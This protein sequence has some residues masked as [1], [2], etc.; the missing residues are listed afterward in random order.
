MGFNVASDEEIRSG[1][2]TD[3]YFVRTVRTL[4]SAGI[5]KRVVMEVTTSSLP[6][7]YKWAVLAGIDEVVHL[8]EGKPV[9]VDCIPEGS[10]FRAGEPVL[11][12]EAEYTDFAIFETPLLGLL[13]QASGVATKAARCKKAAGEKLVVSFGARRMHP[14]LAPMID[15]AAFIGGCDGVAV[16]KS[17]ELLGIEPVG[18]MPHALI[19][20]VGDMVEALKL[21]DKF[22]EPSVR[23]TALIDTFADEKFE[24]LRA[25]EA[26]GEKLYA[27]RFDTPSSR[28]GNMC[29]LL[30]EVRWELDIRGYNHVKLFVSGGVDEYEIKR[31]NE[32]ADV[33]G[34]G[35]AISNA[36]VINF[37]MDIVEVDGKPLAKRGKMSGAKDIYQCPEC[38]QNIVVPLN[39]RP[40]KRC[41]CANEYVKLTQPLLRNGKLVAELPSPKEMRQHVLKALKNL[42]D[43]G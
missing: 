19:I 18:T 12:V 3:I 37:A 16:I 41:K 7:G 2:V 40:Q 25:A 31:L 1:K 27:V 33:Y 4:Q 8:L 24:A 34:V 26:L 36:P 35:T 20:V 9:N 42:E 22:I 32:F 43:F 17:A 38:Y 30:R 14:A 10:I 39:C 29:A 28:R 21:F 11:R 6:D 5:K 15:R 13:C 23:R